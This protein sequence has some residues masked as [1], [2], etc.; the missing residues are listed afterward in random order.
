MEYGSNTSTPTATPQMFR[1]ALAEIPDPSNFFHT[2]SHES[3][4]DFSWDIDEEEEALSMYTILRE[5]FQATLSD[6]SLFQY[7]DVLWLH[8]LSP[9]IFSSALMALQKWSWKIKNSNNFF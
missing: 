3:N 9:L 7:F 1:Q 2:P 5:S 8:R 4:T 6:F